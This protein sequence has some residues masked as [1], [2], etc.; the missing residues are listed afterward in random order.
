[1]APRREL[2]SQS[3]RGLAEEGVARSAGVLLL[4]GSGVRAGG[5]VPHTISEES[6]LNLS[7]FYPIRG[8]KLASRHLSKVN[9]EN[10]TMTYRK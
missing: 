10:P 4:S 8:T 6:A 1:M 9:F 2:V 5:D 7:V 3:W